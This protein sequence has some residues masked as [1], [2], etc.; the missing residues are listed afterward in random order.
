[1]AVILEHIP[2]GK[3]KGWVT[4][5]IIGILMTRLPAGSRD[6]ADWRRFDPF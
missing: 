4:W 5:K 1:M 3:E 2:G 6:Q